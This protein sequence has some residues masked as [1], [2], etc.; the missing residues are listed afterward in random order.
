M[1]LDLP[2]RTLTVPIVDHILI[3]LIFTIADITLTF[4]FFQMVSITTL[5]FT[6]VVRNALLDLILI[7]MSKVV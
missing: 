6:S 2:L 7:K 4:L 1:R 3:G 5:G